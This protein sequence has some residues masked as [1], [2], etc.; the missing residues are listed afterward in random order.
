MK[1]ICQEVEHLRLTQKH[2]KLLPHNLQYI[3]LL[4][5]AFKTPVPQ[6]FFLPIISMNS[7]SDTIHPTL[8]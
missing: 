6:S 7:H 4:F 8:I 2:L 5:T 1:Q 3:V